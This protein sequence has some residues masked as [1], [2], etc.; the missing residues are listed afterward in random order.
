MNEDNMTATDYKEK[1]FLK[2]VEKLRG[3][4]GT[5]LSTAEDLSLAVMNLISLEEHFF[6][7]AEKTGD[8]SYHD[9]SKTVRELRKEAMKSLVP[10]HEGETWCATKHLLSAA[11]R[12]LEVGNKLQSEGKK[13]EAKNM[14]DSAYRVYSIFWALRLKLVTVKDVAK[15]KA[16]KGAA[17]PWSVEDLVSKLADCCKE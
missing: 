8:A 7:T 17:K 9:L 5:D 1:D 12:L 2:L 14:F 10:E 3:E 15:E 13:P 4:A 6:F 11:M 16:D